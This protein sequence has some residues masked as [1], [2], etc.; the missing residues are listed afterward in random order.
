MSVTIGAR[1]FL[2]KNGSSS[3]AITTQATNCTHLKLNYKDVWRSVLQIHLK[4]LVSTSRLPLG[5][6]SCSCSRNWPFLD[7]FINRVCPQ[8]PVGTAFLYHN[9]NIYHVNALFVSKGIFSETKH[10]WIGSRTSTYRL[11]IR[12]ICRN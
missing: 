7:R 9:S 10:I 5:S 12:L 1:L 4:V 8:L 2:K 6:R 3:I 11:L